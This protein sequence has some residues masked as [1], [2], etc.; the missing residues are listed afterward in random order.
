MKFWRINLILLFIIVFGATVISRLIYIQ[1]LNHDFYKALAQGQQKLFNEIEGNRGEIYLQDRKGN[2]YALAIN[3][4]W[5]T[6]YASPQEVENKEE[7]AKKL[8]EILNLEEQFILE[9]LNNQETFY[10]IIKNRL[11]EEEINKIKELDLKGIDLKTVKGRYYPQENFACQVVGFLGGRMIGQYGLEGYYDNVLRGESKFLEIGRNPWIDLFLFSDEQEPAQGDSFV[12]TIDYNIQSMAEKLLSENLENLSIEGGQ[13]IV[14]EPFS[15]KILAMA[16]FPSFNPNLYFQE[17]EEKFQN[18]AIYKLFEPGSVFKVIT[19]AAA[20]D[21][22][23]ITP[24]TTYLDEGQVTIGQYTIY[25][26]AKRN[27]G[28]QTMTEV[29]EKSIN[30]GA[31]F[32]EKQVGHKDF[33]EYV[34]RFAIFEPTGIDLQEETFSQNK[35]LKKGYEINFATASFGQGIEMTPIQLIRAYAAIINGGKLIKPYVVEKVINSQGEESINQPEIV[36]ENIIS[37]DTSA[38]LIAMMVSVIENGFSKSAKVS[39]Y[40]L[41][42]KTGTAQVSW[43][44]LG[45][46]KEGYSDKTWQTFIGFGPAFDPQFLI[47]VK[48]DNPQTRTAEYSAMPIFKELAKYLIDYYQIPPDYDGG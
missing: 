45:E 32:A 26:Y 17:D 8:A 47:L 23:K 20:L 24:A 39:G 9:K 6:V 25:N 3:K 13:I 16:N 36:R 38:E 35:E 10:Q 19:M 14:M 48:L 37:K 42:G 31:V 33:L 29:L 21:K 15:G 27:Y 44:A 7:A 11:S 40:Y 46:N 18:S 28:Q 1:V 34:D 12:L 4:D 30:T 5:Q 22:D 41:G 2:L 43:S